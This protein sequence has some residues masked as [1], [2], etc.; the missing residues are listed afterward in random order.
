MAV[1]KQINTTATALR[2][3]TW[4]I[5]FELPPEG[6]PSVQ[7]YRETVA[8]DDAG[9]VVGKPQQ[10]YQAVNRTFAA[11]EGEIADC[12]GYEITFADVVEAL[13]IF[14]D[15]WA[16]EDADAPPT[17]PAGRAAA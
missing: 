15:R 13:A 8:I 12:S 11:V 14:G 6:D 17:G 10:S 3:Q 4:R 9:T 7:I 5:N 1:T 2:E 16:Q